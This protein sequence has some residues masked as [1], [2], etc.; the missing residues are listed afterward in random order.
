MISTREAEMKRPINEEICVK[1]EFAKYDT[2]MK[3][4]LANG[5]LEPETC[6]PS[7]ELINMTETFNAV[8]EIRYV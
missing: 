5:K 1:N 3:K 6:F 7:S 4:Q 2:C 8:L